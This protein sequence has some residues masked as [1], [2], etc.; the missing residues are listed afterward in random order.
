MVESEK[1]RGRRPE[2][3][4]R[5]AREVERDRA[6]ISKLY[7]KGKTQREIADA[8]QAFYDKQRPADWPAD[9]PWISISRQQIARE[10]AAVREEWRQSAVVDFNTAKGRELARIDALEEAYWEAY[11][12]SKQDRVARQLYSKVDASGNA[13]PTHQ[14]VSTSRSDGDEKFLAGIQWCI[15]RRCK[16]YGLD[17]PTKSLHAHAVADLTKIRE[18][19]DLARTIVGTP[20][21]VQKAN[22]Q[23]LL[24]AA[25][26]Q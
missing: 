15:D 1:R 26:D 5:T 25:G 21:L 6:L 7:V 22:E 4:Q 23:L 12:R 13:T 19:R 3:P 10:L 24:L 2:Q 9:R 16:I 14:T 18:V 20:E 11:E 8:L 17:A